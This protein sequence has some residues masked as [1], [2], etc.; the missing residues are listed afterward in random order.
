MKILLIIASLL[1]SACTGGKTK[2]YSELK[3]EYDKWVVLKN[4]DKAQES[5]E[6]MAE[7][8]KKNYGTIS[9]EYGYS[10]FQ[11]GEFFYKYKKDYDKAISCFN[12]SKDVQVVRYGEAHPSIAMIY[13][14]LGLIEFYQR[15]ISPEAEIYFKKSVASWEL[16]FQNMGL[17]DASLA[18]HQDSLI[19]Q[20]Y[21][22]EYASVRFNMGYYYLETERYKEASSW[23]ESAF[24]LSQKFNVPEQS[25]D[26]VVMFQQLARAYAESGNIKAAYFSLEHL[27]RGIE[28]AWGKQDTVYADALNI[29]GSILVKDNK[30]DSARS[31]AY[32]SLDIDY[33][34]GNVERS[35]SAYYTL[36]RIASQ[37]QQYVEADSLLN[38]VLKLDTKSAG[39]PSLAVAGVLYD[40]GYNEVKK[41]NYEQ[42]EQFLK[43]SLNMYKLLGG[44]TANRI[45]KVTD[46]LKEV[47]IEKSN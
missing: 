9:A 6:E 25:P 3:V 20:E 4:Y 42:A 44:N 31:V 45:R 35:G 10:L 15:Q 33:K 46:V 5:G 1:L 19:V 34:Y 26:R 37:R 22:L 14:Y 13:N 36:A 17:L 12:Q 38:I 11:L 24:L 23:I 32:Q 29:L 27:L 18:T 16:Y 47:G 39:I 8:A 21:W 43:K 7:C 30:L 41:K 2:S 28:I 40:L